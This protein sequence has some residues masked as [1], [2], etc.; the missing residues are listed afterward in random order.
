MKNKLTEHSQIEFSHPLQPFGQSMLHGHPL[1][2][3]VN[4]YFGHERKISKSEITY[5]R[6]RQLQLEHRWTNI[7][8]PLSHMT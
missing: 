2:Q 5:V 3:I 4:L 7:Q 8:N 6:G 1:K